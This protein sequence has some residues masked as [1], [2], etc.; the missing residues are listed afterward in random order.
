[1]VGA[2]LRAALPNTSGSR[3]RPASVS[4]VGGVT[5]QRSREAQFTRSPAHALDL[6]ERYLATVPYRAPSAYLMG[7]SGAIGPAMRGRAP[8]FSRP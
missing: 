1:M 6:T 7:K 4:D 8:H 2:K 3:T 5:R